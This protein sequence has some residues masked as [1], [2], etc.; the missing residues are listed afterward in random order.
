[1][2]FFRFF[3]AVTVS[4]FSA[5][6]AGVPA[7][8]APGDSISLYFSAPFVT[9]SAVTDGVTTE[10]FNSFTDTACPTSIPGFA[11]VTYTPGNCTIAVL[12]GTSSGDSSP[13]IGVPLPSYV[14]KTLSTTFTFDTSVKYV[15]FWWMMGSTGNTF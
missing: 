7:Q 6:G 12:G 5:L 14:N 8:A 10:T 1:M 11:T 2:R 3:Q 13:A 9:G 4:A 15:G